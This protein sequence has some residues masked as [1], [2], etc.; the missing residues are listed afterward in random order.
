MLQGL[1]FFVVPLLCGYWFLTNCNFTKFRV[2]RDSGYHVLFGSAITGLGFYVFSHVVVKIVEYYIPD[3]KVF[4]ALQKFVP[5]ENSVTLIFTFLFAGVLLI[6]LNRKHDEIKAARKVAEQ[7]GDFIELLIDQ[8][9]YRVLPVELSLHSGKS[10]VGYAIKSRLATQSEVDIVLVPIASGYR[11][12]ET[13]EL[14]ITTHYSSIILEFDK[15]DFTDFRIVIP[16]SEIVS[17]RLFDQDVYERFQG[18][19]S[20]EN[21][22]SQ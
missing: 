13:Q 22:A 11:K 18:T 17:A 12:K 10:Y 14:E 7:N 19:K 3:N 2:L 6:S 20:S 15:K 5:T 9:I 1:G 4:L 21:L 8:S 16:M